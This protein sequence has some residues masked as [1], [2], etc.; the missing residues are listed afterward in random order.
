M[1]LRALPLWLAS[2][3]LAGCSAAPGASESYD[4][5]NDDT[6][7]AEESAII[8]GV[9]TAG[10]PAIVAIAATRP[11]Q[12]G[13]SLCTGTVISPT[14]VLTAA[15]CVDPAV[16]GGDDATF[17]VLTDPNLTDGVAADGRLAV[18]EVHWD[19]QF[20]SRN[21]PNGHDIAVVILAEPTTITPIPWN[22]APL[23]ASL[24]NTQVRIVGYGLS[25]GFNQTGAGVKRTASTRLSSFNDKLVTH[26]DNRARICQGDS[27]GPVLARINGVETV[28]GVN[29]YGFIFCLFSGN[30]TRVDTYRSFVEQ[31]L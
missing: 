30:S 4:V 8:G 10:D 3:A 15:H 27:G 6:V 21:L 29:S 23:P 9:E 20:N 25:N 31:Y 17:V 24:R 2:I 28:I 7:A 19:P 18:K 12:E 1:A 5:A 26:G 14:V 11:G 22:S 16:I 13:S